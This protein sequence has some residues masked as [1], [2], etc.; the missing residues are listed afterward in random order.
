MAEP[1]V[2]ASAASAVA[3]SA[4]RAVASAAS[5][6]SDPPVVSNYTRHSS[7]LRNRPGMNWHFRM[8]AI[9]FLERGFLLVRRFPVGP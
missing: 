4:V 5:A 8:H 7:H 9:S 1:K 2:A 6:A 3:V